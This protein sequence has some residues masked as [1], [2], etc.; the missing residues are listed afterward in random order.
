M[1]GE[2]GRARRGDRR[3][4]VV[5]LPVLLSLLVLVAGACGGGD[6]NQAKL[7]PVEEQVGLDGDAVLERQARAEN[8]IRDCMKAQGFDYVPIDPVQQ[9]AQLV[10][11]TGLSQTDFEKQYGYGITT[12]YEERQQAALGPNEAI[13][14]SLDTAGQA[15]Y[16]RALYGDD[17][18]A[19][20]AVALDTGDFTRLGGCLKKATASVF[21]GADV[22]QTLQ[23]K[24]DELD[25]RILADPRMVKA[26][27]AWSTCMHRRGF[28]LEE[29]E[30]VDTTLKTQLDAIVGPSTQP[31]ADYDHDAL[32]A[33]QREEVHMVHAD[34]ACE[35]QHIEP[36]EVGVR[37][38]YEAEFR[39]RNADLL[40]KVPPP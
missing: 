7:P 21:G 26:I 19:T 12:L 13:R 38:E 4:A 24:L 8:L 1:A 36:V 28:D 30:Q 5:G 32:A 18:T 2:R 31:K 37:A 11:S 20:F 9:Q 34:V 25:D 29:P 10:G 6:D 22:L 23:T 15:A 39:T 14:N 16:D 27:A 3:R 40:N 17:P 33:L 35:E